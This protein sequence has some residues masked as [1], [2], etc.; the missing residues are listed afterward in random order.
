MK[1]FGTS[2]SLDHATLPG[3]ARRAIASERPYRRCRVA[4]TTADT[5]CPTRKNLPDR[6][7]FVPTRTPASRCGPSY[8]LLKNRI[9]F[10]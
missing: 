5:A 7:P 6:K 10:C 3:S 2:T 9:N 1:D 4:I 8:K